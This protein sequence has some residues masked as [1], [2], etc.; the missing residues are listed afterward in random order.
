MAKIVTILRSPTDVPQPQL[1]LIDAEGDGAPISLDDAGETG[2]KGLIDML[3]HMPGLVDGWY[4]PAD[5]QKW[6]DH[7][8]GYT[9]ESL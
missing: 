7:F 4:H 2:L 5:V 9:E 1:L 8:V 6:R 3:E